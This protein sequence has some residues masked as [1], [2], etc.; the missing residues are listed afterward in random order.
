[1]AD[2]PPTVILIP[3]LN[4]PHRVAGLVNNIFDTSPDNVSILF[5]CSPGDVGEMEAVKKAARGK[6][7]GMLTLN[8]R[9]QHGDYARKM[10]AGYKATT[11][12]WLFLGADDLRFHPGWLEAAGALIDDDIQVVG[13]DDMGNPRVIA[14]KHSTHTLVTRSYVDEYGT[15]DERNKMLHEGYPHEFVDDE[16]V[17]TAKYRGAFA[18]AFDSKV[19]H[20][21]PNWGKNDTDVLYS[22][23]PQRLEKAREVWRRRCHLFGMRPE[24]RTRG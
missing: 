7:V 10:N 2:T 15:I 4:R 14:G 19:E 3:V 21:H 12:P 17:G 16:F 20:L 24:D 8:V 1:M 11:Q 9:P 22:A 13:T 6:A 23:A 5:I 18:F